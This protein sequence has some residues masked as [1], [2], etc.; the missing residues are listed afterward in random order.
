VCSSDLFVIPVPALVLVVLFV[1]IDAFSLANGA[2]GGV[3]VACQ[4]LL[5]AGGARGGWSRRRRQVMRKLSLLVTVG[6][7]A[8]LAFCLTR[9]TTPNVQAAEQPAGWGTIKG[10]VLWAG[11][12]VPVQKQPNLSQDKDACLGAAKAQG[13]E[14]LTQNYVVNGKTKGVKYVVVWLVDAKDVKAA[15]PINPNLPA[16]AKKV[17]MD[18][19]CCFFEPHIL[20][21]REGQVLEAK[22]SAPVPHNYKIDSVPPNPS[23]NQLIPPGKSLDIEGWKAAN[24]PSKVSCTIHPWMNGYIRVFAHPY[25]AITDENGNFEIKDAPA[26]TYNIVMWQEETG[27]FLGARDNKGVP[28]PVPIKAGA[29]TDLGKFKLKPE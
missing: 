13:K 20:C 25:Y 14:I 19:P 3:A 10:Q 6:L 28:L 26:G 23:L 2:H 5:P 11:G 24:A 18:Q 7:T 27:Y 22:N 8:V 17:E 21:L 1:V 12:D 15:L 16:P 9:P 29:T 4:P